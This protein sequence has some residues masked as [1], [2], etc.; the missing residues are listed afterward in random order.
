MANTTPTQATKP[1]F[2]VKESKLKK[3]RELIKT[4]SAKNAKEFINS[5]EFKQWMSH[6]PIALSAVEKHFINEIIDGIYKNLAND[7]IISSIRLLWQAWDPTVPLEPASDDIDI[8]IPDVETPN[9]VLILEDKSLRTDGGQ[10]CLTPENVDAFSDALDAFVSALNK[11]GIDPNSF[12]ID[13]D[14][15]KKG[16]ES[17]VVSNE[18]ATE[19][20]DIDVS[21]ITGAPN[22][23]DMFK[24][25]RDAQSAGY[26][27]I[28]KNPL[29]G[30][31][32]IP[33]YSKNDIEDATPDKRIEMGIVNAQAKIN[34]EYEYI[35]ISDI[36]TV[37]CSRALAENH[38]RRTGYAMPDEAVS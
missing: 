6:P 15:I 16:I 13:I 8:D 28:L 12:G 38:S 30:K 31:D 9:K 14:D 1:E 5:D 21:D 11:S 4:S 34:Q 29:Y 37:T 35:V 33:P 36:G 26:R 7:E 32:F 27:G 19:P 2:K 17:M 20:P 22:M 3:L 24:A 25:M 10:I 18:A 23:R